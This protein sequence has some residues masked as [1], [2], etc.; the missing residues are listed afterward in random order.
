[1]I[2]NAAQATEFAENLLEDVFFKPISGR[3]VGDAWIVKGRVGAFEKVLVTF[4]IP[5]NITVIKGRSH[6]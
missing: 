1:M 3:R 5:I 4:E 2:T 6:Y